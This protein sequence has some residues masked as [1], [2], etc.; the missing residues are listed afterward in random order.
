MR[1][2]FS[3]R[4]YVQQRKGLK[5]STTTHTILAQRHHLLQ[6]FE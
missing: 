4:N 1:N 5:P 6:V 3:F 2:I